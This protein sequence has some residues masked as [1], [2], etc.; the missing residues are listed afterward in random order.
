MKR[1][2]FIL[3]AFSVAVS[4]VNAQLLYKIS[5]DG[6]EKPSYILG[7][8]HLAPASFVDSIPGAR[9][10]FEAVG[11]VC[12]ELDMMDMMSPGNVAKMQAAMM[13]PEGKSLKDMLTGDQ[14]ESLNGYMRDVLGVD[15][16]NPMIEAQL[17]RMTPMAIM[18]QLQLVQFMK[19]TPGFDPNSVIDRYFQT[20]AGK[21][22]KRILGFENVEF[23]LEVL[24][25]TE[26]E[27]QTEQLF[28][29]IDNVEYNT[30][31]M[32]RLTDAYFSQDIKSLLEITEEKM[33]N[34]CDTTPEENDK[35]IYD[36][37]ADWADKIPAIIGEAPTLIVVG[38]A[39][40]PG[41]RGVLELLR[42]KGY[43]V[44]AVR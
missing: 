22:G 25:G 39:H 17:G 35:L 36:R 40:L 24:Y 11:Q 31:L 33:G 41:E 1:L 12:G 29:M 23:Q 10:A 14:M 2:F 27:R 19:M 3:A 42:A 28:C 7:T 15:L 5:C 20:E 43:A 6:L 44:E 16:N 26:L 9:A 32:Q 8:Y 37:N 18:T 30:G 4:S 34:S 21:A 38:A 13:L